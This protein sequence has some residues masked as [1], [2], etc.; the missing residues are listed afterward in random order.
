MKNG[1][2]LRYSTDGAGSFLSLSLSVVV[3]VVSE[4]AASARVPQLDANTHLR[5]KSL[6]L[7]M[8]SNCRSPANAALVG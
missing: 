3:S 2:L 1:R 8:A 7:L 4:A 5:P 6:G